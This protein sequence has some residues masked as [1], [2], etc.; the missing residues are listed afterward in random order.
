MEGKGEVPQSQVSIKTALTAALT[1]L[2]VV[3]LVWVVANA[4]VAAGLIAASALLAMALNRGVDLLVRLR[5]P[6]GVAIGVVVGAVLCAVA[7]GIVLLIPPVIEQL[8]QMAMAVPDLIDQFR[9]TELYEDFARAFNLAQQIDRF[10]EELPRYLPSALDAALGALTRAFTLLLGIVTVFFVTLFMLVFGGPLVRRLLEEALPQRRPG[11]ERVLGHIYRSVGGYIAGLALVVS[12]NATATT[13]FLAAVGVPYFLP[14]G[15][16]SGISSVVPMI[17][18]VL[19]GLIVTLITL[20][21]RGVWMALLVVGYFTLYQQFENQLLG[22]LVYRR[23][24]EVNPLVLMLA[25]LVLGELF[26]VA[27]AV[28]S[29]PA[30]AIGQILLREALRYRRRR[31]GLPEASVP[32]P[33]PSKT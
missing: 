21:A 2:A 5:L 24:I 16:L 27:G 33:A 19:S 23:T 15:I 4:Q 17:G 9:H 11:Y 32:S 22:P 3:A 6:R 7:G 12:V 13:I 1:V 28:L 26:G 25:L 18:A 31:L 14:L 30:V 8:R 10:R 29:V 20:S